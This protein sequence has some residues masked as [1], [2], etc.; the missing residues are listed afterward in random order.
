MRPWMD[1]SSHLVAA[2]VG[3]GQ[4]GRE[5]TRA[6]RQGRC[7]AAAQRAVVGQERTNSEREKP[8]QSES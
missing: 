7:R 1:V 5:D 8:R 4:L 6:D 3:A 2:V